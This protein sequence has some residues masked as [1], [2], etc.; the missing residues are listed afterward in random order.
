MMGARR[1][2]AQQLNEGAFALYG[3][4]VVGRNWF[5]VV[6]D[7]DQYAVSNA[8]NVTEEDIYHAYSILEEIR[9]RTDAVVL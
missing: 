9:Q 1:G 7:D 4:Y 3:S 5:F 2:Y 8:Y 6:L